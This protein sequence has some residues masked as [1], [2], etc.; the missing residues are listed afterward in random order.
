LEDTDFKMMRQKV[1]DDD[2]IESLEELE[3]VSEEDLVFI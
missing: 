1:V 2:F 3:E